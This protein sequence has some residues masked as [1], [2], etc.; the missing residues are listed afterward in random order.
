MVN[1]TP[2]ALGDLELHPVEDQRQGTVRVGRIIYVG[3]Y[4]PLIAFTT[5][6]SSLSSLQ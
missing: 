5:Y 3:I 6:S 1:V 4:C 2:S